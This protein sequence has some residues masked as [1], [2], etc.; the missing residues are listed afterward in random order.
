VLLLAA[1]SWAL[2]IGCEG[3]ADRSDTTTRAALDGKTFLALPADGIN[4]AV[5]VSFL[6]GRLSFQSRCNEHTGPYDLINGT[7]VFQ[8]NES[9]AVGCNE[10]TSVAIVSELL[11]SKPHVTLGQGGS[12]TIAGPQRSLR[13]WNDSIAEPIAPVLGAWRISQVL[14]GA[15]G[16]RVWTLTTASIL[17][18][19]DRLTIEGPCTHGT[20]EASLSG[21]QLVA[22]GIDFAPLACDEQGTEVEA[23]LRQVFAASTATRISFNIVTTPTGIR[24]ESSLSPPPNSS[25]PDGLELVPPT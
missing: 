1:A 18:A 16:A 19:P 21:R 8:S 10:P 15:G 14:V 11:Q 3:S 9:T 13:L 23:A 4:P 7:L 24:L 2:L 20:V 22:T 5:S 12:L 6:D 25:Q 17:I